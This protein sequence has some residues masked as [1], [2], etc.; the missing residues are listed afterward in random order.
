MSFTLLYKKIIANTDGNNKGNAEYLMDTY[1]VALLWTWVQ[2]M[3]G[4]RSTQPLREYY[5][6]S[7]F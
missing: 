4:W 1:T 3:A 5:N 2:F 6:E 7:Y